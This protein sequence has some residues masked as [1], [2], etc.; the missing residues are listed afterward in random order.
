MAAVRDCGREER[1]E[2][3]S[4]LSERSDQGKSKDETNDL[5]SSVVEES[6]GKGSGFGDFFG[7]SG[8]C[9][10]GLFERFVEASSEPLDG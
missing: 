5:H 3:L 1:K 6:F 8:L 9:P 2:R 7:A 4:A 10:V